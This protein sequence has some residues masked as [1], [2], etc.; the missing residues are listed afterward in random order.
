[1]RPF[2]VYHGYVVSCAF[3]VTVLMHYLAMSY[4]RPP[5]KP[6]IGHNSGSNAS[7]S[8]GQ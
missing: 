8:G 5:V 3:A 7:Q 6:G 1:M 2:T 4:S